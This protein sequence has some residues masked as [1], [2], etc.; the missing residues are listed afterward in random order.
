[1]AAVV[2]PMLV[3]AA[4]ATAP[5]VLDSVAVP[6]AVASRVVPA[7]SVTAPVA[8]LTM[9]PPAVVVTLPDVEVMLMLAPISMKS[10]Q[11]SSPMTTAAP[12]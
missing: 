4:M 11:L 1:M 5:P 2:K 9:L 8:V 7:V 3:V 10:S 12:L 6:V